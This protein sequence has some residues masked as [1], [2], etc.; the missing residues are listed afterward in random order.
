M[1]EASNGAPTPHKL[2]TVGTIVA[3]SLPLQKINYLIFSFS[4]SGNEAE[5]GVEFFAAFNTQ[6]LQN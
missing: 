3:G 2:A 5:S 6:C 4:G 1:I